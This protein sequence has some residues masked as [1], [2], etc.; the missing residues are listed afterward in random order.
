[1]I[2]ELLYYSVF[3]FFPFSSVLKFYLCCYRYIYFLLVIA[4]R[5]SLCLPST[6]CLPFLV[7]DRLFPIL[8]YIPPPKK[9]QLSSTYSIIHLYENFSRMYIR[10]FLGHRVYKLISLLTR[11][12]VPVY[13]ILALPQHS[14]FPLN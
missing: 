12:T 3:Y 11:I 7:M 14:C 5:Y 13:T 1:M 8:S 6:F 2:I 4:T 10:K 9:L